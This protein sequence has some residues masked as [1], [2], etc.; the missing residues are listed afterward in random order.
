MTRNEIKEKNQ[1]KKT[2]NNNQKNENQIGKK[3][4]TFIFWQRIDGGEEKSILE[5]NNCVVVCMR[6]TIKKKWYKVFNFITEDRTT[7]HTPPEWLGY[8]LLAGVC[9]TRVIYFLFLNNIYNY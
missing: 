5:P 7:P 1:L 4:D 3:N 2:T 9:I 8:H 6:H